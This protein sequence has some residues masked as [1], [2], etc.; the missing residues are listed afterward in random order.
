MP[1]RMIAEEVV[2]NSRRM[3]V[4]LAEVVLGSLEWHRP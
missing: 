1:G 4:V 3:Q 2:Q